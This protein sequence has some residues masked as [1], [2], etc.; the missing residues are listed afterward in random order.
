MPEI[1]TYVIY[2]LTLYKKWYLLSISLGIDIEFE[3]LDS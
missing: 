1:Q 3:T 2:F